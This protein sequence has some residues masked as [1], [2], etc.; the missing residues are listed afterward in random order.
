VARSELFHVKN[1][2]KSYITGEWVRI[3]PKG[4]AARD[5][6]NRANFVFLSN[7]VRPVV[8]E[9]D[10]R[11]HC[12]VHVPDRLPP[13]FY[14]AAVEE[15]RNGG[16][17]ALHHWL[18]TEVDCTAFGVSTKPP[19]T[20]AKADLIQSSQDSTSRFYHELLDGEILDLAQ[21]LLP[22]L[23]EDL[24]KL[25]RA[26]CHR[27]GQRPAPKPALVAQL[28]KKHGVANT[29]ERYEF[30]RHNRLGPHGF[31]HLGAAKP[32]IEHRPT[33]LGQCVLAMRARITDYLGGAEDGL[34]AVA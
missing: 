21:P 32:D 14:A 34:R 17:A 18:L 29:R 5:E 26:W 19:M 23:S 13:E 1:K 20:Q 7:E 2:L 4:M 8:L 28:A 15:I 10:D 30:D 12:V 25:Y 22:L 6:R 24:Y 9:E 11:R 33:W 27:T 3:N 31:L 16:V